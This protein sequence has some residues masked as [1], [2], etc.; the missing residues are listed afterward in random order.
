[1]MD[2]SELVMFSALEHWA[3]CPR[4]CALIHIEQ[5]FDENLYTLRG[6]MEHE[7]VHEAAGESQGD[8]RI[9]RGLALWSRRLGLVGKSDVVEFHGSAPFPVEYKHGRKRQRNAAEIQLCAQAMCLEEMTGQPVPKGAIFHQGSRRRTEITLDENLRRRVEEAVAAVRA[10]L[11]S[12]TLPEPVNDA[13]CDLCSLKES[14][15]PEL[16]AAHARL[17]KAQQGLFCAK[18]LA[19]IS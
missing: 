7:R 17:R 9:E 15:L 1:M 6:R 5:T 12:E 19:G 8:V 3:Y 10:L 2:D 16:V 4:Q 18:D 11:S 14:C 13:R